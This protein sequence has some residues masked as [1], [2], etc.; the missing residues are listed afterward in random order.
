MEVDVEEV[1]LML[2]DVAR[3][4]E[5]VIGLLEGWAGQPSLPVEVEVEVE[6]RSR[7]GRRDYRR[8][9]TR[10]GRAQIPS[11]RSDRRASDGEED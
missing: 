6:R 4:L 10:R 1:G 2:E 9:R 3:N 7:R 11:G 8:P 5:G